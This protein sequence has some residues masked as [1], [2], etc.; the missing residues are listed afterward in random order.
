M[1]SSRR[2][3]R[4]EH[5]GIDRLAIAR[6]LIVQVLVLLALS[7]AFVRYVDWSS[8]KA[9]ADFSAATKL[10]APVAQAPCAGSA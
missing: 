6:T 1:L 2:S 5:R 8:A 4:P 7:G 3:Q 9:L 10:S